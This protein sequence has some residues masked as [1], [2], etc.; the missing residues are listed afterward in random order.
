M[1]FTIQL[2]ALIAAMSGTSPLLQR[3]ILFCWRSS[4]ITHPDSS[5]ADTRFPSCLQCSLIVVSITAELICFFHI[6]FTNLYIHFNIKSAVEIKNFFLRDFSFTMCVY[7]LA[8][9]I[10]NLLNCYFFDLKTCSRQ[11]PY[12]LICKQHNL[13]K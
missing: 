11:I 6:R 2:L 10:C 4:G 1:V 7:M 5:K 12:F 13:K 3:R 8:S 9:S